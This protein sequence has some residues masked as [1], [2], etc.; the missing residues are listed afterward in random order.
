MKPSSQSVLIAVQQAATGTLYVA[1][2]AES[3]ILTASVKNGRMLQKSQSWQRAVLV[4]LL[5]VML[6]CGR[7]PFMQAKL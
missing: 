3:H 5:F 2:Q 6:G 4:K 7:V 1:S